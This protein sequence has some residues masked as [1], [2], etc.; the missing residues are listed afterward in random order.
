MIQNVCLGVVKPLSQNVVHAA[1][2]VG[3]YWYPVFEADPL[4]HCWRKGKTRC[5]WGIYRLRQSNSFW[6]PT[7]LDKRNVRH[8]TCMKSLTWFKEKITGKNDSSTRTKVLHT[9]AQ[10]I[11]VN[12]SVT[13]FGLGPFNCMLQTLTSLVFHLAKSHQTAKSQQRRKRQARPLMSNFYPLVN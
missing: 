3:K 10:S 1:L 4:G 5:C 6:Q 9:Y 2:L 13:R 8:K 11:K 7:N 12:K